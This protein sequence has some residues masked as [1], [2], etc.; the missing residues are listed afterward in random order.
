L[1]TVRGETGA[2]TLPGAASLGVVGVLVVVAV[3]AV[4]AAAF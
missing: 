4:V 3:P 1:V 2:C